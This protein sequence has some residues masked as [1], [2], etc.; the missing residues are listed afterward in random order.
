VKGTLMIG[1]KAQQGMTL[2]G[3]IVAAALVTVIALVGFRMVP[4]YIEFYSVQKAVKG[5]LDDANPLTVNEVRKLFDRRV[6]ADYIDSVRASDLDITKEGNE[7][8]ATATWEKR[9]PL[10]A[11]VSLVLDFEAK[12]RR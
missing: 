6:A 11:N 3:F 7:I 9:L 4:A 5:A 10:V 8:V 2:M 12:A 1:R